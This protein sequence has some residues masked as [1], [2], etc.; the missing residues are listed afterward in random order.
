M[1]GAIPRAEEGADDLIALGHIVD[2]VEF[3]LVGAHQHA[4]SQRTVLYYLGEI[5]LVGVDELD[6]LGITQAHRV[7]ANPHDRAVLCMQ[8]AVG[9][10][11]PAAC[12]VKEALKI[13]ELG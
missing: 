2:G 4:T 6:A 5:C 8:Q 1:E 7:R 12:N 9:E 13:G 10:L 3:T 11:G